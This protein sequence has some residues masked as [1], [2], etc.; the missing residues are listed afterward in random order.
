MNCLDT[1]SF[2]RDRRGEGKGMARW[3][4]DS[5]ALFIPFSQ[6]HCQFVGLVVIIV[7]PSCLCDADL[8]NIVC[9]IIHLYI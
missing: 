3:T 8:H 5:D 4:K 2:K 9:Y 7:L 6:V 1:F